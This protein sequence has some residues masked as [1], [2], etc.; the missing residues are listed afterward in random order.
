MITD[1]FSLFSVFLSVYI[2][3]YNCQYIFWFVVFSSFSLF[4][5]KVCLCSSIVRLV[6]IFFTTLVSILI[7]VYIGGGGGIEPTRSLSYKKNAGSERV[8]YSRSTFFSCLAE[9]SLYL[10]KMVA[11]ITVRIYGVKQVFGSAEG[12][13]FFYFTLCDMLWATILYQAPCLKSVE[14]GLHTSYHQDNLHL[15]NFSN[16][17]DKNP[18]FHSLKTS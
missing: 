7:G 10:Y 15:T 8:L 5:W 9:I 14:N 2:C 4:L 1:F 3:L 16:I 6:N 11:Q 13:W 17:I 12:N 18:T